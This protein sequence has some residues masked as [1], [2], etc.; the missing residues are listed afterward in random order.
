M[1]VNA[2]M[3]VQQS[4]EEN[5]EANIKSHKLLVKQVC[6]VIHDALIRVAEKVAK[7]MENCFDT[8]KDGYTQ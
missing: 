5:G 8:E 4:L 7:N 3:A 1:Y 2:L 6:S